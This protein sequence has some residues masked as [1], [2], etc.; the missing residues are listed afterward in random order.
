MIMV[1]SF[2]VGGD[3]GGRCRDRFRCLGAT[4]HNP[5]LRS[6]D[7]GGSIIHPSSVVFEIILNCLWST[8]LIALQIRAATMH[9]D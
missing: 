9:E 1:Y 8:L 3:R 6:A 2:C 4:G 5:V 7:M